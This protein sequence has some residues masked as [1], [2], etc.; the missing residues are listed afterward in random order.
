MT[1]FRDCS[2]HRWAVANF[3]WRGIVV[4]KIALPMLAFAIVGGYLGAHAVQKLRAETARRMVLIYAWV[5]GAYLLI[6][7][8]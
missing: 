3:I 7:N 5:T 4:W 8:A 1:V 6:R 2:W